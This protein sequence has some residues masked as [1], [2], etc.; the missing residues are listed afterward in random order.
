[1][2]APHP[3]PLLVRLDRWAELRVVD[4]DE[5]V[6]LQFDPPDA[7]AAPAYY[8]IH[9]NVEQ[10]IDLIDRLVGRVAYLRGLANPE[11]AGPLSS[12]F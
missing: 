2:T 3:G 11:G 8:E 12:S 6:V 10:A 4:N 1:M 7:P 5:S 9:L